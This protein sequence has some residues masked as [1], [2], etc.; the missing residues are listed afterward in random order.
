MIGSFMNQEVAV[1]NAGWLTGLRES[2]ALKVVYL[3]QALFLV[4]A[5]FGLDAPFLSVHFER[6]NQTFDI[7]RHVF[8]EGLSAVITPKASFS[9]PG[10]TSQPFT[11]SRYE[12]PFHGIFGWPLAAALGHERAAVRLVSVA[13]AL[14]SIY[15]FFR[16]LRHWVEPAAALAGT[17]LWAMVPLV[18][19]LGQVPM[20]DILCTTGVIASFYF[21]LNGNLPA[22]SGCFLFA[23]LAKESVL[24]FGLPILVALL[25]ANECRSARRILTLSIAWGLWPLLGLAAWISLD[26]FSPPTPWTILH[27]AAWKGVGLL[28]PRL[29]IFTAACLFPFGVGVLGM[30]GIASIAINKAPEMNCW[31]ARSIFAACIVYFVF[32][33]RKILEP[34]YFLPLIFWL[35]LAASF[36]FA[37]LLQRQRFSLVWRTA[38]GVVICAHVLVVWMF[39]SD[40]KGAR[41]SN[42]AGIESAAHLIPN[43]ARVVMVCRHYGAGPAV[44]LNHNVV[45]IPG[46]TK[47]MDEELRTLRSAN[48]TYLMILDVESRHSVHASG[49]GAATH[50]ADPS[51]PV[52]Q[53]CDHNLQRLFESQN[54]VLYS[55]DGSQTER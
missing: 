30:L 29:Y 45:N 27:I 34:Q 32:V 6:Q 37:R 4:I 15:L 44:W 46:D 36:G 47:N 5:L 38:L 21:A 1:D 7:A 26:R 20:P 55:L 17:A 48:F 40:L 9:L 8:H 41:V 25:V 42:L 12:V 23:I 22:S 2:T 28:D 54:V 10:Y 51:S 14:I 19:H 39:T 11:I 31:I 43:G 24:P 16:T 13:F 18:L 35:A 52:R 49:E 33:V 53:F 3:L 50:F